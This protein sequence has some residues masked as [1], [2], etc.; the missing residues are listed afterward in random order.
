MGR[1]RGG[2][3]GKGGSECEGVERDFGV[4]WGE[5]GEKVGGRRDGCFIGEG[6]E[7]VDS[8]RKGGEREVVKEKG[9]EGEWGY[10]LMKWVFI[11]GEKNKI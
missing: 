6:G 1:G 9:R 10:L 7:G 2:G 3:R 11:L 4:F 8:E 5:R